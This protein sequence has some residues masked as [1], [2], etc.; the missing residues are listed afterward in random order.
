MAQIGMQDWRIHFSAFNTAGVA[1]SEES[2]FMACSN[3]LVE[4]NTTD[5][6]VNMLTATN[7]LSDLGASAIGGEGNVVVLGYANG[8]I[9]IIEPDVITNIPWIQKAEIAGDKAVKQLLF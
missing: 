8:N 9:D 7:G 3:G 6:S 4:Y 2:I 1:E 5:N